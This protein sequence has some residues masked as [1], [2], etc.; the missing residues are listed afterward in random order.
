MALF[1]S[2]HGELARIIGRAIQMD[3]ILYKL[4]TYTS[5]L[6]RPVNFSGECNIIYVKYVPYT[7][8]SS[9]QVNTHAVVL[10][11]KSCSSINYREYYGL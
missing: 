4:Y 3:F 9:Y 11:L 8:I 10:I 1:I 7:G 6:D 2:T 5:L